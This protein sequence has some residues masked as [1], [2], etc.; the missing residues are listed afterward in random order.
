[1]QIPATLSWVLV[2]ILKTRS[3]QSGFRSVI[4]YDNYLCTRRAVMQPSSTWVSVAKLKPSDDLGL[5]WFAGIDQYR[6]L[7]I[8]E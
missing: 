6:S 7:E 4:A 3:L 1:M 8:E 2:G 5:S